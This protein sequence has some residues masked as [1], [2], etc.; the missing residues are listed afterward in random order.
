[1]PIPEFDQDPVT[2]ILNHK[3]LLYSYAWREYISFWCGFA[4][5]YVDAAPF[6]EIPE[7][8]AMPCYPADG[9]IRIING[10]VVIKLSA[11]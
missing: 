3:T 4:P 11:D 8:A 1:M 7:V 9:S 6:L 2:P 10:T 5:V